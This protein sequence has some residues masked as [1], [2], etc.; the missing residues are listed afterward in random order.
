MMIIRSSY[1][2]PHG[3]NTVLFN[4]NIFDFSNFDV[5]ISQ[6]YTAMRFDIEIVK[7]KKHSR[8][9]TTITGEIS[10][11]YY[12]KKRKKFNYSSRILPLAISGGNSDFRNLF[13][14]DRFLLFQFE[15]LRSSFQNPL[16]RKKKKMFSRIGEM[17]KS[18]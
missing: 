4:A 3:S 8:V 15:R 16:S 1:V 13:P 9:K 6:H 5:N 7:R 2:W 17:A 12:N 18:H 11:N 10:K 14:Y